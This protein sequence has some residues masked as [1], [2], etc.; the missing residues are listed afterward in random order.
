MLWE[1]VSPGQLPMSSEQRSTPATPF[2][3]KAGQPINCMEVEIASKRLLLRPISEVYAEEIFL[4]FTPEVTRYMVPRAAFHIEET[5]GFINNAMAGMRRGDNLQ[6]VI[7]ANES[8]EFLGCCGL[9]GHGS[10]TTPE[11]GIWLKVAAHGNGYGKEAITAL[12]DWAESHLQYKYLIYP[13]DRVN[14]PSR[15]IPEAL[16]GQI[17]EET[18]CATQEGGYLDIVIYRIYPRNAE[19]VFFLAG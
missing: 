2:E 9:H 8:R 6:F 7:L 12:V 11:L 3:G 18:Q 1:E 5:L 19:E 17:F 16:D 4:A 10:P 14:I 13:V 15:K